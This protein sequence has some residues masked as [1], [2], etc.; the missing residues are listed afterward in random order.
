SLVTLQGETAHTGADGWAHEVIARAEG[1]PL[2]LVTFAQGAHPDTA[3]GETLK[4][5]DAVERT[6]AGQ[7][8]I[9]WLITAQIRQ[10][11]TALP[12]EPQETLAVAALIGR[13]APLTLLHAALTFPEDVVV[14]ALEAACRAHLLEE[15]SGATVAYQF[16]H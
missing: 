3:D 11:V 12:P 5:A 9:P 6:N 7:E 15:A 13:V 10:R 4:R 16:T 8:G 1:V 14:S 2:Y